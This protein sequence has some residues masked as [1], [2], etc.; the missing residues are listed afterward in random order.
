[1]FEEPGSMAVLFGSHDVLALDSVLID[2][3]NIYCLPCAMLENR[4]S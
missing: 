4:D 3:G 1:M 2:L